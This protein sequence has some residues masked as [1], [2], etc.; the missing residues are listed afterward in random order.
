LDIKVGLGFSSCHDLV[1]QR[2]FRRPNSDEFSN[3]YISSHVF[4][5]GMMQVGGRSIHGRF[6]DLGMHVMVLM[7]SG[8]GGVVDGFAGVE[9]S[10][11][12]GAE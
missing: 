6:L 8:V 9:Q 10:T 2:T 7:N 12:L 5:F 3:E 4:D 1:E 11:V